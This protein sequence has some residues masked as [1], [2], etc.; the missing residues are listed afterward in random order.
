MNLY[1]PSERNYQYSHRVQ[2]YWQNFFIVWRTN[3]NFGSLDT[4]TFWERHRVTKC[5]NQPL[6][7]HVYNPYIMFL[8]WGLNNGRL[9]CL[10]AQPHRWPT[11]IFAATFF[12]FSPSSRVCCSFLWQF[13]SATYSPGIYSTVF[14]RLVVLHIQHISWVNAVALLEIIKWK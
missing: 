9:H 10:F 1:K 14:F 13:C 5:L 8:N 12:F 4:V 3:Q 2:E 6:H 7:F 11:F